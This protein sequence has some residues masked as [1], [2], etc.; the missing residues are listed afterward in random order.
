G[1][2]NDVAAGISDAYAKN[3]SST[4]KA[5]AYAFTQNGNTVPTSALAAAT[6]SAQ[7]RGGQATDA[8]ASALAQAT[9]QQPKL[10]QTLL[11]RNGVAIAVAISVS[12]DCG[13]SS[14]AVSTGLARAYSTAG[15][16]NRNDVAQLLPRE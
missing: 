6:A 14:Q 7:S 5:L 1:R 11:P 9:S 16:R 15:A 3:P 4:S 13:G 2:T 10:A 12:S 8:F